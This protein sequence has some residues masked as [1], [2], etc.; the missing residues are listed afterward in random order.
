MECLRI[1]GHYRPNHTPGAKS[2]VGACVRPA[3]QS[4]DC[5]RGRPLRAPPLFAAVR[6]ALGIGTAH[7]CTRRF[8]RSARALRRHSRRLFVVRCVILSRIHAAQSLECHHR[9]QLDAQ[10]DGT[11]MRK[12][13]TALKFNAVVLRK[14]CKFRPL[15]LSAQK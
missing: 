12:L 5:H 14:T 3:R 6:L 4:R 11:K 15:S 7:R 1:C 9:K 13:D 8:L 2:G 10:R